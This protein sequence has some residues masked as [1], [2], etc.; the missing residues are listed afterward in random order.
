MFVS[1]LIIWI[2]LGFTQNIKPTSINEYSR[3][4]N[5]GVYSKFYGV[6][7]CLLNKIYYQLNVR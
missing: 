3:R 4:I 2:I 6:W 1:L 7:V 5:S